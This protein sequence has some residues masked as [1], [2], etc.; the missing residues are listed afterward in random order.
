MRIAA[1]YDVH[2]NLPAL[3]A[4]LADAGAAAADLIVFGGD[5]VSGPFPHETLALARSLGQRACFVRGNGDREAATGA[6]GWVSQQL[7]A[8]ERDF[9]GRTEER[10]VYE[11]EGLGPT[12]F[13]HAS[14]RSD[15]EILTAATPAEPFR[16]ALSGVDERVVVCGHT[17]VQ[18]ERVVDGVRVVNAGSVGM[19]YGEVGAYWTLLG[20]DVSLRQTEYDL[21][22]AAERIRSS[23]YPQGGEFAAENVVRPPSAE[24]AIAYFEQ[25]AGRA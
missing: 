16:Q 13:C 5:V 21:E 18:F 17:H 14:P 1:L 24:E 6:A 3:E 19:P 2:G 23:G 4:V 11:V 8:E 25:L 10:L 20:P 9:L 15:E 12:L 22:A 7:G